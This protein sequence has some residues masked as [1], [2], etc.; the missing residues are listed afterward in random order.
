M[1]LSCTLWPDTCC[2]SPSILRL[3]VAP[4][5]ALWPCLG[6]GGTVR[7]VVATEFTWVGSVF[8]KVVSGAPSPLVHLKTRVTASGMLHGCRKTHL[9]LPGGDN[10]GRA[11][12]VCGKRC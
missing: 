8:L 7:E 2:H 11:R 10:L 12:A 3:L 6:E 4:G 1:A 5:L 9:G